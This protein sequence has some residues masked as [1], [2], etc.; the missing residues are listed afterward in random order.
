M[1]RTARR[2]HSAAGYL[3]VHHYYGTKPSNYRNQLFNLITHLKSLDIS[4]VTVL[5]SMNKDTFVSMHAATARIWVLIKIKCIRITEV[6]P[7]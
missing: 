2:H 5:Q 4:D 3:L 6:L 7:Y 1:L